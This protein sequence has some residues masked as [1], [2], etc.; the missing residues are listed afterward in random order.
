[1]F[2][3]HYVAH[4]SRKHVTMVLNG[5]GGDEA[6]AG[7]YHYTG[8]KY[9]HHFKKI[10]P[11]IRWPI[12]KIFSSFPDNIPRCRPYKSIKNII[13]LDD[14]DDIVSYIKALCDFDLFEKDKDILLSSVGIDKV[15]D[16][17]GL[18]F[19]KIKIPYVN[20]LL[21]TNIKT[22]LPDEMLVKGDISTMGNSLEA[23][24]PFLD[25][26]ILE[27]SA[28]I[29]PSLQLK[30]IEKKHMLK[31]ALKGIIPGRILNRPK[32]GFAPPFSSWFNN[33]IIDLCDNLF[34]K[35]SIHKYGI[36]KSFVKKLL[37][38]HKNKKKDESQKLWNILCLEFWHKT[39]E[40]RDDTMRPL[41]KD[42]LFST[43]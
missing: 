14:K 35:S 32:L 15:R 42:E 33:C 37:A 41:S 19:N 31:K 39:Y 34:A 18:Y 21:Y 38:N 13:S 10:P 26:R 20:K 11:A 6:F 16:H 40:N 24:S 25:H 1:M 23:R 30:G 5:D 36:S 27:F 22:Y 28:K 43:Q 4:L 2:P 12:K 29:H 7:Y 17:I 3:A 9:L 8:L